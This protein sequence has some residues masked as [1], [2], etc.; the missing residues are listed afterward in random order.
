MFL[1]DEDKLFELKYQTTS[2]YFGK[3][4]SEIFIEEFIRFN[5]GRSP[6]TR[7]GLEDVIKFYLHRYINDDLIEVHFADK[8]LLLI[9]LENGVKKSIGIYK[10]HAYGHIVDYDIK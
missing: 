2:K 3:E 10:G 5:T 8:S 1:K 9:R 7:L 6:K 4:L